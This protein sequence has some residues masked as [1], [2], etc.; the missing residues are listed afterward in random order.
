MRCRGTPQVMARIARVVVEGVAHHVTQRGNG[1]QRVFHKDS[2]YRLYQQLLGEWAE[3]Y[4]LAIWAYCLMPNHVHLVCVPAKADSMARALGRTHADF[5][6]HFNIE[7]QSCGHMW[8]ARFYSCP[9]D[10][11]HLW[12]AMAYVERNPVRANM[13]SDAW[14]YPWSSAA[15][16]CEAAMTDRLIELGPWLEV[17]GAERWREVLGSS[18]GEEALAERIRTATR[19][20]WP[21]GSEPFVER[22]ESVAGRRLRPLPSGRRKK[23]GHEP[24]PGA[25]IGQMSMEFGV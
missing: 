14:S 8:Q 24:K 10:S 16:H 7:R 11:E 9:L 25:G 18:V 21:L 1:R 23:E 3:R 2:D 19:C 12:R 4:Q 17:Y 15:A 6:R 20:G 13:S 22:L 5:A